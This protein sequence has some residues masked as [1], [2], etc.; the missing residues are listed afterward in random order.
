VFTCNTDYCG[1]GKTG[2]SVKKWETNGLLNTDFEGVLVIPRHYNGLPVKYIYSYA[3]YN[4]GGITDI[5]IKARIEG[6]YTYGFGHLPKL[7][8]IN[9]PS[10]CKFIEYCGIYSFNFYDEEKPRAQGLLTITFEP[11]SHIQ[12]I[13]DSSI[14]RKDSINIILCDR[15][16]S[17]TNKIYYDCPNFDVISTSSFSFGGTTTKV[18]STLEC[19]N[20]MKLFLRGLED[21]CFTCK[22]KSIYPRFMFFVFLFE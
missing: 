20:Y 13:A 22:S 8:T 10:T 6:I 17:I 3:F 7:S 19:T 1:V 4:V 21:S 2:E 16:T 18:V 11:N 12:T 5:I 14:G 9:I 15:I